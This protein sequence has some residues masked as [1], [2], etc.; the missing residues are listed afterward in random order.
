MNVNDA[1]GRKSF[2]Q[3]TE[4]HEIM[5]SVKAQTTR[6]AHA[7]W[8]LIDSRSSN[9]FARVIRLVLSSCLLF[10]KKHLLHVRNLLNERFENSNR[11]QGH[12]ER[13]LNPSS[14]HILNGNS[15]VDKNSF[16][17]L[18]T[19]S[20]WEMTKQTGRDKE[21]RLIAVHD[22]THEIRWEN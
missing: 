4:P 21:E 11:I 8:P 2:Q 9:P 22:V 20:E 7:V 19:K 1:T 10:A 12:I 16:R 14:T 17:E 6:I 3:P 15:C 13:V 18:E 5:S